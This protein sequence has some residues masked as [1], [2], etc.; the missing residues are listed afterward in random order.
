MSVEVTRAFAELNEATKLDVLTC[1]HYFLERESI[2]PIANQTRQV[3]LLECINQKYELYRNKDYHS[4]IY[5]D[6]K[7]GIKDSYCLACEMVHN[8]SF[9]YVTRSSNQ[10]YKNTDL[11]WINPEYKHKEYEDI[12][13]RIGYYFI[14]IIW[15]PASAISD[16]IID[17]LRMGYHVVRTIKIRG[18]ED[19]KGFIQKVY[20]NDDIDQWKIEIKKRFL[21]GASSDATIVLLDIKEPRF[22]V[23]I[24]TGMPT[25]QSAIEIKK[26][27]RNKYKSYID[28]YI[29]DVIF[30]IGDNYNSNR[31]LYSVISE[32]ETK[33]VE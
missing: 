10:E 13:F 19:Y 15:G 17:D 4:T 1:C 23:N 8:N 31:Y 30:H 20:M 29:D 21:I 7:G 3:A 12:L 22:K 11:S 24:R 16:K 14:G 26:Y 33:F 6:N 2:K 18:I 27:I 32:Y 9:C 28:N 25:S 5:V